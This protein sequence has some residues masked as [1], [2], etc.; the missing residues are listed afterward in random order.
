MLDGLALQARHAASQSQ[1][2]HYSI[3]LGRLLQIIFVAL[4]WSFKYI[5]APSWIEGVRR[6]GVD[7][8]SS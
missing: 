4:V 6:N 8:A 1:P 2:R 5:F 3:I 7:L